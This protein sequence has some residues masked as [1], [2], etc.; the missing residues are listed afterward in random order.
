MLVQEC[1]YRNTPPQGLPADYYLW[2]GEKRCANRPDG[3]SSC[4]PAEPKMLIDPAKIESFNGDLS[5]PNYQS[6]PSA[7]DNLKQLL[8]EANQRRQIFWDDRVF[9]AIRSEIEL[10]DRQDLH[11]VFGTSHVTDGQI[12]FFNSFLEKTAGITHLALEYDVSSQALMDTM[13]LTGW[14]KF[15]LGSGGVISDHEN[16]AR[17]RT[18]WLAY[19]NCFNTVF[20][21]PP[22]ASVDEIKKFLPDGYWYS[23]KE[24]FAVER[25]SQRLD[26]E[27]R[28]VVVWEWG[29]DHTHRFPFYIRNKMPEARTV[30][31][32]VNGGS[33]TDGYA[34]DRVV[35]QLGWLDKLFVLKLDGYQY[36]YV[37]HI[38]TEG[39][40]KPDGPAPEEGLAISRLVA[41]P[42]KKQPARPLMGIS[43][44]VSLAVMINYY[45]NN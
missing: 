18:L 2:P 21:N 41:I 17:D 25:V 23:A 1:S 30:T 42:T 20:A 38:P 12:E 45:L 19:D 32:I 34:F 35:K 6:L 10:N 29:A 13:F 16:D 11:I 26:P 9:S 28:E 36:D 27:K 15:Q 5:L 39:R 43:T 24:I 44:F 4:A 8:I 33:Y 40:V 31:I 37:L 7:E 3:T 22:R 14:Q